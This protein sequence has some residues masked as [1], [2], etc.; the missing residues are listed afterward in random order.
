M[1][2]IHDFSEAAE[3]VID[4]QDAGTKFERTSK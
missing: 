3:E 1:R 2:A 4:R